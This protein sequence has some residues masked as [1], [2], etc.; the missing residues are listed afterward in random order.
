M[1]DNPTPSVPARKMC[2]IIES[3]YVAKYSARP[4]NYLL[5]TV[6]LWKVGLLGVRLWTIERAFII[7]GIGPRP[8]LIIYTSISFVNSK[9][10]WKW[11]NLDLHI[12][13]DKTSYENLMQKYECNESN[14]RIDFE[15]IDT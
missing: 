8:I 10:W 2:R 12:F 6:G 4:I 13:F 5:K 11:N 14:E 3:S 15:K 1:F 9:S 7:H